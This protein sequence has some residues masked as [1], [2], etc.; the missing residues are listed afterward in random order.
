[1]T[2]EEIIRRFQNLNIWRNGD[3][4]A[5]HKPLLVLYAIG[6]LLRGEDRLQY[7]DIEEDIRNLLREFGPTRPNYN[8]HFPFW[9]LQNDEIW[10]VS[11]IDSIRLT[12]SGD[13]YVTD[14]RN[15][16]VSGCFSN[17][18]LTRLQNDSEL[19]CEIVRT[20]LD[21]HF[22]PSLHADILH[23]VGIEFPLLTVDTRTLTADFWED[24][25]R[26]YEYRCAVC[27][28]DLHLRYQLIAMEASHIKWP[29][30]GGPNSVENGLALCSLHRKLFDFGAFTLSPELEVLVSE[31]AY[32]SVGF[33]EWLMRFH[34]EAIRF[35]PPRPAYQPHT[36]F[37]GWHSREVFK[38]PHREVNE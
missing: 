11:E 4:R 38:G 31:Y 27:G 18:I 14:L 15:Y 10:Q 32:G 9:R 22:Q 34:G 23:T 28:F 17:A 13:A 6:K 8:P 5:P 30:A 25:L 35:P 1:M 2:R 20:V 29:Q 21:G 3:E 26:A 7:V 36:D 24:V 37:T 16:N 33:E 12:E 19:T